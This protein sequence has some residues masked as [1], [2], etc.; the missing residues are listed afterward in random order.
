MGGTKGVY[1]KTRG[2]LKKIP[3]Q[4]T[5]L[6]VEKKPYT[7]DHI[8]ISLLKEAQVHVLRISIG[9]VDFVFS[10]GNKEAMGA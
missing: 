10:D 6:Q 4:R 1:I 5:I 9:D 2:K 8:K 7:E 3:K